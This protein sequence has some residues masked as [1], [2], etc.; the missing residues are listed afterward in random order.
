MLIHPALP[1]HTISLFPARFE[2]VY[3]A[4]FD[5]FGWQRVALLTDSDSTRVQYMSE[6]EASLKN[7]RIDVAAVH[8]AKRACA[9]EIAARL[10][11]ISDRR[12]IILDASVPMADEILC[13]AHAL[14]MTA[15][16]NYAWFLPGHLADMERNGSGVIQTNATRCDG[17]HQTNATCDLAAAYDGH[18]TLYHAPFSPAAN[19]TT[20]NK[21]LPVNT[22]AS[23]S[24]PSYA[25]FAYDAVLVL[26]TALAHRPPEAA[27]TQLNTSVAA[28]N[29]TTPPTL[30]G[31]IVF[32]GR[33]SRITDI[34]VGQRFAGAWR[35]LYKYTLDPSLAQNAN[36][37]AI[38]L[39]AAGQ[40]SRQLLPPHA[41]IWSHLAGSDPLWDGTPHCHLH[42]LATWLRCSCTAAMIGVYAG[43]A[44]AAVAAL[45]A[46]MYVF[47]E[48]RYTARLEREAQVLR[49][50]GI[51]LLA[52]QVDETRLDRSEIP[53]HNIVLNRRLGGGQFGTVY[54]GQYRNERTPGGVGL[55]EQVAIK[56]PENANNFNMRLEFLSEAQAM[57]RFDHP[58]IVRLVGVSL[59]ADPMYIVMEYMVLGDLSMYLLSRRTQ[60]TRE[61][62][63]L[64][65]RRL[66]GIVL[67]LARG[68]AYMA[69]LRYVHRDIACRNCLLTGTEE[70][71]TAK[72]A[73]FGMTR[74]VYRDDVY[75]FRRRGALPVRWSAPES[76]RSGMYSPATDVWSFGVLMW[77][78]VTLGAHPYHEVTDDHV[79]LALIR[80]GRT[81]TIPAQANED[82][83]W[84]M[85][86]CWHLEA[87]MRQRAAEIVDFVSSRP[88]V[89]EPCLAE[90]GGEEFAQIYEMNNEPDGLGRWRKGAQLLQQ[91]LNG[92]GEVQTL[93][94]DLSGVVS[95]VG[96]V[97]IANA[98][99]Y[100][101]GVQRPVFAATTT[102]HGGGGY[103]AYLHSL[104]GDSGVNNV[105][106][107]LLAQ[108]NGVP[109]KANVNVKR[110]K[111]RTGEASGWLRSAWDKVLVFWRGR[112]RFDERT[113]DGGEREGL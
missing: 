107:P 100:L 102:M 110:R 42:A 64:W 16:H 61:T 96:V 20:L 27:F 85:G 41:P 52:K 44:V 8:I 3:R 30:S 2:P 73:D 87:G 81:L 70:R 105:E 72:L 40:L 1:Q 35:I 90:A 11:T 103:Q 108:S 18:L 98:D 4:L 31:P 59:L 32:A 68:L 10:R 79:L 74:P 58:N 55:C 45:L 13:A 28:T 5:Q 111:L 62:Q 93:R 113:A 60:V 67:D 65:S 97:G 6:L 91:R 46:V 38:D 82:L 36:T 23:H 47:W 19:P 69:E 56:T 25:G 26:A 88:M 104:L 29:L 84:L 71:I 92:A 101:N 66:T 33:A 43:L 63:E 83:R 15:A 89:V 80:S 7:A 86:E 39:F 9:P 22:N 14:R 94:N 106:R 24:P 112:Q 95:G 78:I 50:F 57:R 54:F 75:R 109:G 17:V 48:R 34:L 99:N 77:E 21:F 37:P 76:M 53:R 51:D 12:I 49:S